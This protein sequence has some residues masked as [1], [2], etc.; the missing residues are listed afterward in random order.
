MG[1]EAAALAVVVVVAV[2][3]SL[4]GG[5]VALKLPLLVVALQQQRAQLPQTPL[6]DNRTIAIFPDTNPSPSTSQLERPSADTTTLTSPKLVTSRGR[7]HTIGCASDVYEQQLEAELENLDDPDTNTNCV[8]DYDNAEESRSKFSDVS[9]SLR[10]T[11]RC[12]RHAQSDPIDFAFHSFELYSFDDGDDTRSAYDT[13]TSQQLVN[14]LSP[15]INEHGTA[16]T[17][18]TTTASAAASNPTSRQ[19]HHRN[20]P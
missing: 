10:R 14:T 13:M 16:T 9:R 12:F 3:C 1:F 15:P 4:I 11:E 8:E 20:L 19:P 5:G 17:T 6:H 2:P 18:T 7:H